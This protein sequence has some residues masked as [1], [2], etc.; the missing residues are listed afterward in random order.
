M[1]IFIAQRFDAEVSGV[2]E[3]PVNGL[4]SEPA[5]G[6]N[7]AYELDAF[8]LFGNPSYLFELAAKEPKMAEKYAF[9]NGLRGYDKVHQ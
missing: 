6:V 9:A 3:A 4:A 1:L 2:E 8:A 7:K 5:V